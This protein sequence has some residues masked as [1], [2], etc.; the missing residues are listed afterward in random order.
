MAIDILGLNI[1]EVT[2]TRS[3]NIQPVATRLTS[4]KAKEI[5]NNA[6]ENGEIKDLLQLSGVEQNQVVNLKTSSYA[7]KSDYSVSAFFRADMPKQKNADG[8]YSISG[9]DFSEEELVKPVY[10]ANDP[11]N[12]GSVSR[13]LQS[14]TNAFTQMIEKIKTSQAYR[15]I[16]F[17]I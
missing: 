8:T 7:G 5:L 9:V 4:E 1:P 15:R 10:R 11:A 6:K 3:D 2:L 13:M 12:L 17:S 14:D 16:D